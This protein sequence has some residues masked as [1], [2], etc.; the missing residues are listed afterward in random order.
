[1]R[2]W[3]RRRQARR[4]VRERIHH[5]RRN[6]RHGGLDLL[7]ADA[8]YLSDREIAVWLAHRELPAHARDGPKCLDDERDGVLIRLRFAE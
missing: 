5:E 1:M 6:E 7:A 2:F 3:A 4:A 8:W